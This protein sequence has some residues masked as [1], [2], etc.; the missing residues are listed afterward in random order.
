MEERI[1]SSYFWKEE[2][3]VLRPP[4]RYLVI[5]VCWTRNSLGFN[6]FSL[7]HCRPNILFLTVKKNELHQFEVYQDKISW[8]KQD[9][10]ALTKIVVVGFDKNLSVAQQDWL[11]L[12]QK[13]THKSPKK[14][15]FPQRP[16]AF[17]ESVFQGQS[18][19]PLEGHHA[20][21]SW[22]LLLVIFH[23][24]T[25][26]SC[27]LFSRQRVFIYSTHGRFICG[28]CGLSAWSS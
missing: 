25:T 22:G 14:V 16:I 6:V 11:F 10:A 23:C 8:E 13:C 20:W 24:A 9:L 7:V 21:L 28:P 4:P 17:I 1:T 2:V 5:F 26:S 18:V 27:G 19:E 12:Q 15:A 3:L